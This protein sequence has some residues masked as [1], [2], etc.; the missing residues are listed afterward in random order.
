MK[1]YLLPNQT[2]S[3]FGQKQLQFLLI[4]GLFSVKSCL[5]NEQK[6]NFNSLKNIA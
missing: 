4:G 3:V 1:D 6:I 2:K 5:K